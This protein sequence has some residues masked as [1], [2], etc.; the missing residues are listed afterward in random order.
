M[1]R[2][3]SIARTH[4]RL[5]WSAKKIHLFSIL[6]PH[7][8]QTTRRSKL[9]NKQECLPIPRFLRYNQ[10]S[11]SAPICWHIYKP[12]FQSK[13]RPAVIASLLWI[14]MDRIAEQYSLQMMRPVS[15]RRLQHGNEK[16]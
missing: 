1:G 14:E 13:A 16:P 3:F 9:Q 2:R 4:L 15:N 12:S 6:A 11:V 8:L 7:P 5:A 10:V